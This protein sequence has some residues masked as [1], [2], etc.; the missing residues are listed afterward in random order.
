MLDKVCKIV[1]EKEL[2]CDKIV[3]F[4]SVHEWLATRP[5]V[6]H[7][8]GR[9]PISQSRDTYMIQMGADANADPTSR[10]AK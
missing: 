1:E 4:N 6:I 3:S 2:S 10:K 8:K 5:M 7:G 9:A